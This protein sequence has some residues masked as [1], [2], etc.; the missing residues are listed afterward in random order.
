MADV[1]KIVDPDNGAGTDYTSLNAWEAQNRDLVAA[2]DTE[3][4]DCRASS[5]S[6]DTTAVTVIGWTTGASNNIT[7]QSTGANAHSGIWDSSK[8]RLVLTSYAN[9]YLQ[10][11]YV[12]VLGLQVGVTGDSVDHRRGIRWNTWANN[13]LIDKCI[14]KVAAS[15]GT[16]I[17]GIFGGATDTEIRNS[18]VY[19]A[20][21]SSSKGMDVIAGTAVLNNNTVYDCTNGF[22]R[23]AGTCTVINSTAIGCT[24][25]FNGTFDAASD[26]NLSDIASDAPGANSIDTTQ[27][28][29]QLFNDATVDDFNVADTGSDLY[30]AGTDLSGT[31]TDDIAGTTRST[32]DIGAFEYVPAGTTYNESLALA[33]SSALTPSANLILDESLLL[34]TSAALSP[35]S[36]ASLVADLTLGVSADLT[37]AT[38]LTLEAALTLAAAAGLTGAGDVVSGG[39]VYEESLTL[40]ASAG[41]T[42]AV[43]AVIEAATTLST[44]GSLSV[45]DQ[46]ELDE[47]L[48]LG[49]NASLGVSENLVMEVATS[50]SAIA[51]MVVYGQVGDAV[52]AAKEL[53]L[54]LAKQDY[55]L[56]LALD[57]YIAKLS[58]DDFDLEM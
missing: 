22:V 4:A 30:N 11:P 25:G 23:S 58:D 34:S 7:I 21:T 43:T 37:L 6:S 51:Q 38:V 42:Q 10:T 2:G 5:G 26:Y 3:T 31:F 48:S 14:V 16:I 8:Y 15:T 53:V 41:I 1:T 13:C 35:D 40:S 29:A 46:V 18:I 39:T 55:D 57:D 9:L 28:D 19:G 45:A 32:W 20:T 36:V 33:V 44:S 47:S 17:S 54:N 50:L 27:T 12:S 56:E 24:D 52:L 49:V